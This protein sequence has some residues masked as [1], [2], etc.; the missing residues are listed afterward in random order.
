MMFSNGAGNSGRL[1][2][3]LH[4]SD[5]WEKLA[6]QLQQKEEEDTKQQ[7]QQQAVQQEEEEENQ[8]AKQYAGSRKRRQP[9]ASNDVLKPVR[10]D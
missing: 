2:E 8:Q 7:H 4:G 9:G 3:M 10:S 1:L 6:L 5:G